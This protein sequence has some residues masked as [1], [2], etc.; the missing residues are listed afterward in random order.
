MQRNRKVVSLIYLAC[1]FVVW[2]LFREL[3]ASLWVLAHLPMPADWV[4][5]PSELLAVGVGIATF[6][7]LLRNERVV[8]FTNEVI[9]ELGKV[10]WPNRKETVISTGVVSVLV[11]ICSIILFGF[12]VVWGAL[13]RVFYQ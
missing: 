8:S 6:I 1:G 13:V 2:M 7:V 12:D 10:V 3:F 5:A 9:T 11:G 4:V